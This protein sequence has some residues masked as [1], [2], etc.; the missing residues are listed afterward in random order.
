MPLHAFDAHSDFNNHSDFDTAA[1]F[2]AADVNFTQL[3]LGEPARAPRSTP[4]GSSMLP[5]AIVIAIASALA[6]GFIRYPAVWQTVVSSVSMI[7]EQRAPAPPVVTAP[8]VAPVAPP[9]ETR[10]VAAAP[11][12]GAGAAMP[13]TQATA[14]DDAS[15]TE[16]DPPAVN[17][18]ANVR[19]EPLTPPKADPSDPNQKRAL[20]AGLHPDISRALLSRLTEADYRNAAVAVRTALGQTP[21][22]EVLSYPRDASAKQALFEVRFVEGAGPACRRY[23]VTVTLARWSTTALPMEKCGQALPKRNAAG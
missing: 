9:V 23:V 14:D 8:P 1:D 16:V 18:E 15:E 6:W 13:L 2:N 5:A 10:D 3:M 22:A 19:V 21:D 17:A 12:A 20:A 11:G 7:V 4:R